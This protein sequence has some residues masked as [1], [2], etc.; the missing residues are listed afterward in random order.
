MIKQAVI[1]VTF[2]GV[3]YIKENMRKNCDFSENYVLSLMT[4][5]QPAFYPVLS[6]VTAAVVGYTYFD[7]Y[8]NSVLMQYRL[9]LFF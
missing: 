3:I 4:D 2:T 7:I 5:N 9:L 8:E 1:R 6:S